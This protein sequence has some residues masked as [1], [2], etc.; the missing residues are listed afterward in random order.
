[1]VSDAI[2]RPIRYDVLLVDE[3]PRI[4]LPLLFA[5]ACLVRERIVLAGD[6]QEMLPPTPTSY[7][8][9]LGWLTALSDSSAPARP[10]PVQ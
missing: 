4:P 3:G 6:P 2:F 5:C 1:V 8:I 7:G 10:T 9:S